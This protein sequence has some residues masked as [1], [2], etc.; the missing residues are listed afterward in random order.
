MPVHDPASHALCL[1]SIVTSNGTTDVTHGNVMSGRRRFFPALLVLAGLNIAPAVAVDREP[2]GS[3]M[4]FTIERKGNPIG[5]HVIT[6][7]ASES[8]ARV[9]EIE[10][11]IRVKLAFITVYRLDHSGEELWAES[12]LLNMVTSTRR[13]NEREDVALRA[14]EDFFVLEANGE[15]QT[16][17]LDLVP[18][19]F[20]TPDFWIDDGSKDFILL[21]TLSGALRP[22]RLT[23]GGRVAL[24]IDDQAFDTRYYRIENLELGTLSH[25]F[26]ID[27]AGHL[28]QGHL[29][30]KDG[31]SLYYKFA[32]AEA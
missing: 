22:S 6:Y 27:D 10:A 26:W 12:Q 21:D 4:T 11:R 8:G 23:Y 32:R 17:P 20:T 1:P 19:S 30:T 31:E 25:E 14:G 13:N 28:V 9:V 16:A 3:K 15:Q 2:D 5:Y 29:L 24:E 18:S 7:G